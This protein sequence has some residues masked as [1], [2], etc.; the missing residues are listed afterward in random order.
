MNYCPLVQFSLRISRLF[1][2]HEKKTGETNRQSHRKRWMCCWSRL[3]TGQW[4]FLWSQR[5]YKQEKFSNLINID[6]IEDDYMEEVLEA[7]CASFKVMQYN[8]PWVEYDFYLS[9]L[10]KYIDQCESTQVK[11][12]HISHHALGRVVHARES[13]YK[14]HDRNLW[15][16]ALEKARK[17]ELPSFEVSEKWSHIFER[18]NGI[19]IRKVTKFTTICQEQSILE[20]ENES[21]ALHIDLTDSIMPYFKPS[22]VFNTIDQDS[23]WN[24][25]VREVFLFVAKQSSSW[26]L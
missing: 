5:R 26:M 21:I 1:V 10:K 7:K 19:S 9:R 3:W 20:I 6:V 2:K 14:G 16:W 13:L 11:H 4:I 24:N 15:F 8:W 25:M 17:L 23:I 12:C 18:E 22:Q